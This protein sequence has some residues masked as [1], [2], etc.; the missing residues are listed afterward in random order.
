MTIVPQGLEA[1]FIWLS[2]WNLEI[3]IRIGG[4]CKV[5][6]IVSSGALGAQ[7]EVVAYSGKANGVANYIRDVKKRTLEQPAGYGQACQKRI[8]KQY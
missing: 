8:Y 6:A 4:Q 3:N 7:L 2:S 1:V 5:A